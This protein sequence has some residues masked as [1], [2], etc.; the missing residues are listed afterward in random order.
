MAKWIKLG[1]YHKVLQDVLSGE[2]DGEIPFNEL[3]VLLKMLGCKL[4]HVSDS[5]Q[6]FSYG[7]VEEKLDLQTDSGNGAM[8]SPEHVR[9][10]RE[11]IRKYINV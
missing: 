4:D 2:M 1:R 9:G 3:C 8:A 6:I 7:G 5:R 10:V 11:F